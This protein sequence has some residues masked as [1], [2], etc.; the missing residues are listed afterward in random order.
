MRPLTIVGGGLTGL[1]LAIAL[2]RRGAPV[3]VHEAGGYPRHRVC[4]EFISGVSDETLDELGIAEVFADAVPL[5]SHSWY[6]LSS[7]LY[8]GMLPAPA[9]GLTRYELDERLHDLLT[10]FGGRVITNSRLS[11]DSRE[12]A[13]WCTGRKPGPGGWIGLKCHFSGLPLATDLE[14]HVGSNGYL[15]LARIGPDAV[16]A[17]GLFRLSRGITGADILERY[18]EAGGLLELAGRMRAADGEKASRSA[19]AGFRLGWQGG[20]EDRL[21]LGDACAMIPPFTGNGMS[22]AFESAAIAAPVLA[23]YSGGGKDWDRAVCE[24]RKLAQAAFSSR[25]IFARVLHPFLTSR[26]G[27]A[28]FSTASRRL[29]FEAIFHLLR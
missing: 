1:S 8:E 28:F 10:S 20:P 5:V 14:M 2:R 19:V 15:G 18:A 11:S 7:R 17:C 24:I 13:V 3:T 12:G 21:F 27:R 22:M 9:R 16:N 26:P 23:G 4:G 25:M 6:H 29:P